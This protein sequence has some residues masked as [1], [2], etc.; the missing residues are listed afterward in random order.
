MNIKDNPAEMNVLRVGY[1][2]RCRTMFYL[3]TGF[4]TTDKAKVLKV[5]VRN[6]TT[7]QETNRHI[8]HPRKAWVLVGKNYTEKV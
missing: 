3:V 1:L 7:G 4:I 2:F 8:E 6:L 5:K